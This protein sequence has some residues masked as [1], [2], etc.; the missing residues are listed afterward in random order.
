MNLFSIIAGMVSPATGDPGIPTWVFILM[1]VAVV[2]I[3]ILIL[4]SK[5][6]RE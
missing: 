3:I 4:T 5:K 1:A 2:G 6:N